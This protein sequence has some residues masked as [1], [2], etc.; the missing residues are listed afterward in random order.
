[1]R[2]TDNLNVREIKPLIAPE[3]LKAEMPVTDRAISTVTAARENV[4]R[5]LHGQDDRLLAIVGPCSIHDSS[6][7][8]DY[9]GRLAELS[10]ELSDSLCIL[11]RTY[12]EKPR[13]TVGWRGMINDP[14]LDGSCDMDVG[15]RRARQLLLDIND[16]GIGTATEFLEPIV[17]QYLCDL[18]SWCAIGARTT[19][20]QTHR[21]MASGLSMPVGFKNSTDGNL[22]IA[23]DAMVASRAEHTFMGIDG[24]GMTSIVTTK[25]NDLVHMILRGGRHGPNYD[26]ANVASAIRLLQDRDLSPLLMIDCSHANSGK[27]H[28]NQGMVLDSI[29]HQRCEREKSI[30]GFMIESS[31][32]AGSQTVDKGDVKPA[33]GVSITDQCIG[34]EETEEILRKT[35]D[36]M[37]RE[38]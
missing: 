15:L 16:M 33:Y 12:F 8:L 6:E 36:T 20:S 19:E 24:R 18:V 7:A 32:H 11:M 35:R 38:D 34:W 31:I 1:M 28:E 30:M 22:D 17:P 4:A 5:I 10:A 25:G 21:E 13:T 9:A 26:P 29:V 23:A 14:Y 3:K 27:R 2:R 37:Q